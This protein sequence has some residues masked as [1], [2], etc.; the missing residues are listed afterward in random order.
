MVSTLP[1]T[2]QNDINKGKGKGKDD[3]YI[4]KEVTL[5]EVIQKYCTQNTPG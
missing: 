5:K 1:V 3:V 4:M 2:L